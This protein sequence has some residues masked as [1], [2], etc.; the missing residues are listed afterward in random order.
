MDKNSGTKLT[1]PNITTSQH[2]LKSQNPLELP[3]NNRYYFQDKTHFIT[4]AKSLKTSC[5]SYHTTIPKI[6]DM[7]ILS[8][9]LVLIEAYA[10]IL[11][12]FFTFLTQ[13]KS[14]CQE[15]SHSIYSIK[16]SFYFFTTPKN[17]NQTIFFSPLP[18]ELIISFPFFR[19]P[20]SKLS[21]SPHLFVSPK[22][23]YRSFS[24]N[25]VHTFPKVFP[26]SWR[27]YIL[28]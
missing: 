15:F 12:L 1:S 11:N 26:L 27:N 18:L 20:I 8:F 7:L 5:M 6:L 25:L 2:P 28:S 23:P 13:Q 21:S 16:F 22:S 10:I 9:V 14:F 17:Q 3:Q 19:K 24:R 4:S